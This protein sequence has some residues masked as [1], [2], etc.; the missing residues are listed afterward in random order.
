MVDYPKLPAS[1]RAKKHHEKCVACAQVFAHSLLTGFMW[2]QAQIAAILL[3]Q[4]TE[5]FHSKTD[6]EEEIKHLVEFQ[7]LRLFCDAWEAPDV[8]YCLFAM[9]YSTGKETRKALTDAIAWSIVAR[10]DE[11]RQIDHTAQQ[12]CPDL[13]AHEARRSQLMNS[14]HKGMR[15]LTHM[16][17]FLGTYDVASVSM[18]GAAKKRR[19][20]WKREKASQDPAPQL[21][22]PDGQSETPEVTD[23]DEDADAL[24]HAESEDEEPEAEDAEAADEY[25]QYDHAEAE[26]ELIME[27]FLSALR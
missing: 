23:E 11:S 2:Q 6:E 10:L 14:I 20:A 21:D 9:Q 17:R 19:R 24:E 8:E 4:E 18:L 3:W 7:S 26:D 12:I 27:V 25:P 1:E 22:H 15:Q 16:A 13:C 5:A